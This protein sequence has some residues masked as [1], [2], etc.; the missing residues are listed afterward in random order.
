MLSPTSGTSALTPDAEGVRLSTFD[1]D[2]QTSLEVDTRTFFWNQ[3]LRIFLL[4]LVLAG[5][6]FLF[7]Q[8]LVRIVPRRVKVHQ[9]VSIGLR[10]PRVAVPI[11]EWA[12]LALAILGGIG[13]VMV[14]FGS[15]VTGISWDEPYDVGRLQEFFR[16]GWYVPR[17]DISDG[18]FSDAAAFPYGPIPSLFAHPIS[19]LAGAETWWTSATNVLAYQ[20]RHLGVALLSLLGVAAVGGTVRVLTRSW[21]WGV[22]AIAMM[23]SIPL[24][25][26]HSMFNVK[27]TPAAA[28]FALFT[29]A[30]VAVGVRVKLTSKREMAA[31]AL[32]V[33]LGVVLALGSRPGLW[34]ALLASAAGSLAAWLLVDMR[35]YPPANA[36]RWA[37][38]RLVLIASGVALGYLALWAIYPS[39]YGDPIRI[40]AASASSTSSFPSGGYTLTAGMQLPIQDPA[41]LYLPAWFG[42]QLPVV[43]TILLVCGL[44]ALA[45]DIVRSLVDPTRD[46]SPAYG[47]IPVVLQVLVVPLA[48]IILSS[49]LYGGVRQLLFVLP[50]VAILATIGAWFVIRAASQSSRHWIVPTAWG[51]VLCGLA[52]PTIAQVQLF[53][54]NYAYF[55]APTLIRPVDGNW[56]VDGWWLSGRELVAKAPTGDRVVCVESGPRPIADCLTQGVIEPFLPSTAAPVPLKEDQFIAL[57]R[58]PEGNLN[59]MCESVSQ[60]SRRLLW[61][62]VTMSRARVCDAPLRPY[63]AEG[64]DFSDLPPRSDP[65]LLWGWDPYL[66]WGWGSPSPQGVE[67]LGSSAS[68]GFTLDEPRDGGS[69]SLAITGEPLRADDSEQDLQVFVNG[70]DVGTLTHQGT[71]AQTWT[72]EVPLEAVRGIGEG[73][74]VLR[75]QLSGNDVAQAA[76]W[77]I[78]RVS[79]DAS[80]ARRSSG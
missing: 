18:S 45:T 55:N 36:A 66:L 56:D 79:L 39:A 8:V 6:G 46:Y 53:P 49:P 1:N 13:I 68:I 41:W 73:R 71:G 38:A 64:L 50:G 65:S 4:A 62:T 43:I 63:P 58:L 78:E 69:M 75:L 47:A 3:T 44:A 37:A 33:S 32:L 59:A 61:Q 72:L 21:K 12:V 14:G 76:A 34:L 80:I 77:R 70:I 16:S 10:V 40:L 74:V 22:L 52:V 24:W 30:L 26:G 31:I 5:V 67:T 23:V 27:D 35:R 9:P 28:G 60:V 48:A 17:S 51:V 29:L 42:S 11:P 19:V 54:Y 2:A 15:Q 57:D 7:A 25:A 20:T